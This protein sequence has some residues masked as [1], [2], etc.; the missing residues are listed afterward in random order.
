M[1]R[2]NNLTQNIQKAVTHLS[3]L[4]WFMQNRE[5]QEVKN[6][7]NTNTYMLLNEREVPIFGFTR[8][9]KWFNSMKHNQN[10][11]QNANAGKT[12]HNIQRHTN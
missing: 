4:D 12:C 3:T 1:I 2:E 11:S 8:L 10:N 9:K 5:E 6:R 7:I